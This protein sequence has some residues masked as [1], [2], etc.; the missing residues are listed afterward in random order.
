MNLFHE[1]KKVL[2]KD[3]KVNPLGPH[4]KSKL[5]GREI[6]AYFRRNPVKDA[7]IRKA[8]TVALDLEGAMTTAAKEIKK[9]YG[10]KVLKSKEV[11]FALKYA[12]E[13]VIHEYKEVSVESVAESLNLL[14][15]AYDANDVKKVQQLEKKFK[16]L[17]KEVDKTMKGSGISAPAFS[18]VRGGIRKGLE[19]IEKFYKVANTSKESINEVKKQ[20]VDAMKKVSKDMQSVLKSYQK[21]AN[22]GDKELK[23]TK[24]NASYKKVLDARNAILTMIGTLN[25]QMLLKKESYNI[26]DT[27]RII[28]DSQHCELIEDKVLKFTK[29]KDKSLEKHLKVVT[30]KVGAKLEKISGGFA[31][32]DTDMRGFTAVVDYI[33]D[34][35]IKKNMLDGGGMS[36]VTMANENVVMSENYRKLAQKGMGTETKKDARVGLELDYYDSKGNKHMGKITKKTATGYTV[37]DDKTRKTHTFKF[38]D[39]V[40]A[41]KLLA[42]SNEFDKNPL[43]GFPY[44]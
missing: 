37:Q 20:E 29:V 27:Y 23:N 16:A 43:K 10:D 42:A 31:V 5:T 41:K 4:G 24:H 17:L 14:E 30:K 18:M 28:N 15:K 19:S 33:F 26:A 2:D 12:N 44:N 3:G 6:S 34:K 32:S 21:I 1:A 36:D 25:T 35:S 39:R 9:F 38:H 40:D 22:M 11:Q 13:G 8:V 7:T